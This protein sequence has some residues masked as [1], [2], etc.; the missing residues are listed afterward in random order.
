MKF[1]T[2]KSITRGVRQIDPKLLNLLITDTLLLLCLIVG[3]IAVPW[4]VT[5]AG[6]VSALATYGVAV[7]IATFIVTPLVSP[8]GDRIVKRTQLTL[9]ILAMAVGGC[10][11]AT[12]ATID[13][14]SLWL[15]IALGSWQVLARA[16]VDP[17]CS[18]SLAEVVPTEKLAD[19]IRL[20]KMSQA[21]AGISGPLVAGGVLAIGGTAATLWIYAGL[22]FI[23]VYFARRIPHVTVNAGQVRGFARWWLDLRAGLTAKWVMPMERGWTIVNFVVWIF[24]G[25]SV[26]MLIPIKVQSLQLSVNWLAA[27]VLALSV[28]V[29]LG[30]FFGSAFLVNRF[31]RFRVRVGVTSVEGLALAV[32]GFTSSPNGMIAALVVA[33]FANASMA[34]VGATHRALAIPQDFRVRILAASNMSTQIAGAIGPALVAMALTRWAVD[35]VYMAFGLMMAVCALG[36]LWVP[37]SREFLAL[38][39]EEVR[40]W[41]RHQYPEVFPAPGQK[42]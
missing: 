37:R 1:P 20:R 10:V 25:P 19:A 11:L 15:L 4:W 31:G 9:G 38:D 33:G 28:G 30:S 17:A 2:L 8:F 42:V 6:G 7:A 12:L 16:V 21:I 5:N 3:H 24:Q 18:T 34:L 13:Y 40:N 32:A 36:F 27:S 35:V 22:L 39:H 23:A 41:Y 26:G 14:F 29:F